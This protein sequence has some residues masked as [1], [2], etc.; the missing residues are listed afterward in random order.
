MLGEMD[1]NTASYLIIGS[2]VSAAMSIPAT[3]ESTESTDWRIAF[4]G[5]N[6]I[7]EQVDSYTLGAHA[8]FFI[9]KKK[10]GG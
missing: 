10:L 4:G 9:D 8:G 3:A 2:V 1:L 7:V 6:T 5:H